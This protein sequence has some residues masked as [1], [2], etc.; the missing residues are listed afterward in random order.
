MH[1]D[2]DLP[3]KSLLAPDVSD[4]IPTVRSIGE[5]TGNVKTS[6][7]DHELLE[8]TV[9]LT[10]Q[11]SISDI[12]PYKG[13]LHNLCNLADEVVQDMKMYNLVSSNCQ[14]FCNNLLRRLGK[15]SYRTTVGHEVTQCKDMTFDYYATVVSNSIPPV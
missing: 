9:A 6:Q 1:M 15:K 5:E 10:P 13:S 7:S 8:Y 2:S 4:L 14:H 12:G 11:A 3:L